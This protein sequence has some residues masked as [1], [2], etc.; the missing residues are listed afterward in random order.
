MFFSLFFLSG[1]AIYILASSLLAKGFEG[2]RAVWIFILIVSFILAINGTVTDCRDG[3]TS[4]IFDLSGGCSW[5]RSGA[6]RFN[7]FG[8]TVAKI[9]VAIF[10]LK[11]LREYF[12]GK[13][14]E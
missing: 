11:I 9:S 14:K 3:W 13:S 2:S 7:D 5:H 4:H 8:N 6:T 10:G 12:K 1:L